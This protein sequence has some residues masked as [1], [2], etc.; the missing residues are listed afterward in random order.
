M[1]E[2]CDHKG[3]Y[4]VG[5]NGYIA[6]RYCT[7][8]GKSWRMPTQGDYLFGDFPTAEWEEIKEPVAVEQLV[9]SNYEEAVIYIEED[10]LEDE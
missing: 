7:Q 5:G 6:I 10:E 2:D 4:R 3:H 9:V 8:C 1:S